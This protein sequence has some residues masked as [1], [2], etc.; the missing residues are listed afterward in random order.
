MDTTHLPVRV[1]SRPM[2]LPLRL[3]ASAAL[4]L[5]VLAVGLAFPTVSRAADNAI[6]MAHLTSGPGNGNGHFGGSKPEAFVLSEDAS[7]TSGAISAKVVISSEE[8][9]TRFRL[10][11]KYVSDDEWGFVAYDTGG[12]I[13]QHG[14]SSYGAISGLP[15][16]SAGVPLSLS[17]RYEGSD[18]VVSV[19]G[20]EARVSDAG[21]VA[22]KDKAGKVGFGGATYGSAST[23]LWFSGVTVG[24]KPLA[25]TSFAPYAGSAEGYVWNAEDSFRLPSGRKW[26]TVT[27]GSNNGGGHEYGNAS[28]AGPA[29]LLDTSREVTAGDTVSLKL[30]PITSNNLGVFYSYVDNDNWAYIGWDSSSHW[31]WQY[32]SNGQG[33]YGSFGGDLP[34]PS[35]DAPLDISITVNRENVGLAVGGKKAS[36]SVQ[37]LGDAVSGF[38]G[39]HAGVMTKQR[40]T[41]LKFSEFKIGEKDCMED[42]WAFAADRA[43]Q[44]F[45]EEY[46]NLA[47]LTGTVTKEDGTPLA[48]ATVR[49]GPLAAMTAPTP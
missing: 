20:T 46:V 28:A 29:L 43:G 1:G 25:T 33:T 12:W 45:T 26:I 14:Q 5:A 34:D 24:E 30:Q 23:D 15:K 7:L 39:A 38:Q 11:T 2:C 37:G 31:Y 4:A 44:S 22:L 36:A 49:V 32:K 17:V 8:A 3:L 6:T 13:W 42:V 47:D 9:N 18:M 27:S 10:V 41:S 35:A 16:P 48:G 21:M 40:N 19:D